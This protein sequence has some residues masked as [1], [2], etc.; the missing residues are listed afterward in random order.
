MTKHFARN[1]FKMS[2][3]VSF[4]FLSAVEASNYYFDKMNIYH[5]YW[6]DTTLAGF[7]TYKVVFNRMRNLAR[8]DVHPYALFTF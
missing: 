6:T 5:D 4:G 8:L 3:L 7:V 2:F 1:W